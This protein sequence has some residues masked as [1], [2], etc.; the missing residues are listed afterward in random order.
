MEIELLTVSEVAR[1]LASFP[2]DEVIRT[3]TGRTDLDLMG[4]GTRGLRLYRLR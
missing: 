4:I 1:L 3:L 2:A